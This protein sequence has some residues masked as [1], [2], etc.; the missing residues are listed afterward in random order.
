MAGNLYKMAKRWDLAAAAFVRAA[1]CQ[2][3]IDD[4]EVE[5]AGSYVLAGH[6]LKKV[7]WLIARDFVGLRPCLLFD[8]FVVGA[9]DVQAYPWV[10][11][12]I[13]S[14]D[15]IMC[16]RDA[17][18]IYAEH[19]RW[20]AAAKVQQDMAELLERDGALSASVGEYERAAEL[21]DADEAGALRNKCVFDFVCVCVCVCVSVFGWT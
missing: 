20:S 13:S 8:I 10:Q 5:V 18:D 7:G 17:V 2:K 9:T 15:A 11:Q 6:C 12:Q 16:Y 14:E 21:Y 4:T 1:E 3:H 19:G